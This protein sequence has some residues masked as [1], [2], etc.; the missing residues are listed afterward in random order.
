METK[1]VENEK[2]ELKFE[3]FLQ[4]TLEEFNVKYHLSVTSDMTIE[5]FT[6]CIEKN[7]MSYFYASYNAEDVLESIRT[8]WDVAKSLAIEYVCVN[9]LYIAIY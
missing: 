2:N 6:D 8:E 3:E 7:G 4:L 5:M 9:G 1:N